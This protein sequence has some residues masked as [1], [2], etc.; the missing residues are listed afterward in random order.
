M[1]AKRD[2]PVARSLG[3]KAPYKSR[4][5]VRWGWPLQLRIEL[6]EKVI[7]PHSAASGR[8]IRRFLRETDEQQS[9]RSSAEIRAVLQNFDDPKVDLMRAASA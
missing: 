6:F 4:L 1:L 3:R 8:R 9:H 7:Q 2:W 5:R